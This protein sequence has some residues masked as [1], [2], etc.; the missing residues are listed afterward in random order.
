MTSLEKNDFGVKDHYHIF[1]DIN[2]IIKTEIQVLLK[3]EIQELLKSE[4]QDII[5]TE[6]KNGLKDIK[7][8]SKEPSKESSKEKKLPTFT[9]KQDNTRKRIQTN[10]KIDDVIHCLIMISNPCLYKK[11]YK[12]ARDFMSK[13]YP[14]MRL[15]LVEILYKNQVPGIADPTNPRHLIINTDTS[16]LWHKENAINIGIEKLLPKNWKAMA[17][18]DAD[19]EFEN[20]HWAIDTL[21]LLNDKDSSGAVIPTVCQLFSHALDLNVQQ[22]PMTVFQGYAY[23]YYNGYPYGRQGLFFWHPGYAWACNR[24][25][26]NKMG[27]LYDLSI[28]GSGDT[29]MAMSLTGRCQASYNKD[30]DEDYKQSIQDYQERCKGISL[31]YT[32][33]IIRH[34]YHGSKANRK[35]VD[36]WMILV[37]YGYSPTKH[38][39]KNS[40]GLIVPTELCPRGLIDD[41]MKYF[42]ERNEDE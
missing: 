20:V 18:I 41:I 28:L 29:N 27:S 26:Y 30:I 42:E 35:Y 14:G 7:N 38:V 8:V 5:K 37:K 25:A 33:G 22:D 40:D 31:C 23:Q 9:K 19:I 21:K 6:I 13:S 4:M 11:R 3:S 36:R 39:K 15:Y 17:W 1:D 24:E 10:P 32:P 16:P 12:L 34:F 2:K